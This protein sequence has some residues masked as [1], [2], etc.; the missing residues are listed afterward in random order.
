M[1]SLFCRHNRFT[2]DCPICSK[3]TVL[4]PGRARHARGARTAARRSAPAAAPAAGGARYRGPFA[5][6]G[7]LED[8]E[9]RTYEVR[10][11]KVPGGIRLGEWAGGELR[12]RAPVLGEGDLRA[13]VAAAC[14]RELLPARDRDALAEALSAEAAPAGEQARPYGASPGRAGELRDELRV[15][16]VDDRLLRVAR[17]V[18]RP[19]VGFELVDA[20]VMLPARRYAEALRDAARGGLLSGA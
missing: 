5:A 3:G 11:E 18:R 9:G 10:L 20:P 17:W 1:T 16:P 19:G 4:D 7:P 15:E 13:L 6:T 14:E 2:V 8:D 12:R